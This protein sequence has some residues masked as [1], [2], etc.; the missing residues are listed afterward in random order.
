M[1]GRKKK[2][3]SVPMRVVDDTNWL[4]RVLPDIVLELAP[5]YSWSVK[6]VP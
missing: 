1:C 4:N 3:T 6:P 5:D 2:L